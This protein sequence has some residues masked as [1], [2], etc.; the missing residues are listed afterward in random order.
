M[1]ACIPTN[2]SIYKIIYIHY[3]FQFYF[4]SRAEG[5]AGNYI[6]ISQRNVQQQIG[7]HLEDVYSILGLLIGITWM[8]IFESHTILN[9]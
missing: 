6:P 2:S 7:V 8:V 9:S 1:H 5:M 4:F 3:C